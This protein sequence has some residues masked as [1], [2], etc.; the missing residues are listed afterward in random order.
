M[1][2]HELVTTPDDLPGL[3]SSQVD[4]RKL[5]AARQ[6]EVA[7]LRSAL[8]DIIEFS[9]SQRSYDLREIAKKALRGEQ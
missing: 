7:L 9:Y 4:W 3:G 5:L 6:E 2:L 1:K 8:V